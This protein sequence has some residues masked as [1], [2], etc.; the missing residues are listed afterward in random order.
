MRM[1][2]L[3][4]FENL[5]T[6]YGLDPGPMPAHAMLLGGSLIRNRHWVSGSLHVGPAHLI[7]TCVYSCFCCCFLGYLGPAKPHSGF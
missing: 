2:L 6:E 1:V 7:T 5:T 4:S 3:E